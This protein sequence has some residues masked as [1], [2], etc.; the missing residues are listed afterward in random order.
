MADK[1]AFDIDYVTQ[2]ARLELTEGEKAK[3]KDQLGKILEYFQTLAA[4]DTEGVE[5][6]AHANPIF[7]VLREDKAGTP[8][9]QEQALKNA[10]KSCQ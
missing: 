6:M 8:F 9:T 7:D 3:F 2:L 4:I 1:D 5:P 10:P